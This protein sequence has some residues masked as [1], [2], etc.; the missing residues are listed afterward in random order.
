MIV[1]D[2]AAKAG[3]EPEKGLTKE[4]RKRS[5]SGNAKTLGQQAQIAGRRRC[6]QD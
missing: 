6:H 2:S 4:K 3:G 1:F 5:G